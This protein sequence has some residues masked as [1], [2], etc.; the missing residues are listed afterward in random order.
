MIVSTPD[1][2]PFYFR[3]YDPRML[4]LLLSSFTPQETAHFFGPLNSIL[5]ADP[6]DS[7]RLLE[8]GITPHGLAGRALALR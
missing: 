1:Q 7:A 3:Y 8:Y 4:Q 6:A 5:I 2:R